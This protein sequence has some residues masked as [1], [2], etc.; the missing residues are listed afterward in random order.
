MTFNIHQLDNLPYDDVEPL[1]DDY[2]HDVIDEFVKSEAGQAHIKKYPEGGY[3][4][5]MFIEMGYNYGE[6]T[7]PTMTQ[8]DV[9]LLMQQTLPRKLILMNPEE[10]DNAIPELVAFWGFLQDDYKLRH[11]GQIRKYL[12]SIQSKFRDWMS[13]DSGGGFVKQFAMQGMS[14]GFD[15]TTQEGLD[16]FKDVYNQQ[17]RQ[18]QPQPSRIITP[19]N[20][21]PDRQ[22]ETELGIGD[23]QALIGVIQNLLPPELSHV[24]PAKLLYSV[25]TDDAPPPIESLLVDS[26]K[27]EPPIARQALVSGLS[28]GRHL[29]Y[30]SQAGE[31]LSPTAHREADLFEITTLKA[32]TITETEPGTILTDFQTLLDFIAA[33][34]VQVS[35]KTHQLSQK[36]LGEINQRLS[37][38]IEID[39][40]RPMQKSYP[41]IHGLYLLLRASRL[42]IVETQGKTCRLKLNPGLYEQWQQFNPT[43]RYFTL[44]ETWLVRG[45]PELLGEER[46]GG[47]LEGEC[48]VRGW[49]GYL[50]QNNG[51]N[52]TSY[53]EQQDLSYWPKLYNLVLMELF[54]LVSISHGK[55]DTGKGWRFNSVTPLPLGD[56]IFSL[57]KKTFLDKGLIWQS[58]QN[59]A[60]PLNELQAAFQP[61]FPD[62]QQYFTFDQFQFRPDRHIFK[63][64]LGK[65]WRKLAIAGDANLYDLSLLILDSVD[66]DNDHLHCFTYQNEA[67]QKVQIYHPYY[68]YGF[69]ERG[70]QMPPSDQVRI[71]DLP[72]KV[73][74]KMEY[75]FDFG[76][77]WEFTVQLEALEP[78]PSEPQKATK[79][80]EIIAS[81]GKAPKQ[82]SH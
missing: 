44:L 31:P 6:K 14:A 45:N 77:D 59:P 15:M 11:A 75:L 38:P 54:G 81:Q 12:R 70:P 41:N 7:L 51:L 62:W 60:V 40:K 10:A 34:D 79:I 50:S 72:L 29:E 32:Q 27:P 21:F 55:P 22:N 36:L 16:A 35:G 42:A 33:E 57:F 74:D 78:L 2:I 53:Q 37:K 71:G 76:D 48:C 80:G 1:L 69:F 82:Y 17:L 4:I 43:E 39:L 66:F 26:A 30:S 65:M 25:L 46:T 3:W 20:P 67:G 47:V 8:R 56:A 5:G 64:S 19:D 13:D 73:G 18:Q 49:E 24:D 68:E 61:Y 28:L 58:E 52:P 63:V 9:K 23:V